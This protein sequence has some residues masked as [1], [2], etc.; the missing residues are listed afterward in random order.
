MPEILAEAT[1][2]QL[3]YSEPDELHLFNGTNG[4]IYTSWNTDEAYHAYQ[5]FINNDAITE[6]GRK[7]GMASDANAMRQ[8]I[9]FKKY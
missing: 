4:Y 2:K 5:E 1:K 8:L 9:G 3:V 6:I 7:I